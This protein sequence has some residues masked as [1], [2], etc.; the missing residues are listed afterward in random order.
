M[1]E[2]LNRTA[3]LLEVAFCKF[4][5]TFTCGNYL[6]EG[7]PMGTLLGPSGEITI[8]GRYLDDVL[9]EAIMHERSRKG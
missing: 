7:T 8:S 4:R 9:G 1:S 3:D 2:Q 6:F 5:I